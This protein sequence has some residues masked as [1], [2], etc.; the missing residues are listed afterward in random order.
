MAIGTTVL[1]LASITFTRI[2]FGFFFLSIFQHKRPQR[3]FIWS[4]V[5]ITCVCAIV[6]IPFDSIICPRVITYKTC[7]RPWTLTTGY[8]NADNALFVLV[9]L[10]IIIGDFGFVIMAIFALYHVQL[11]IIQKIPVGVL[12]ALGTVDGVFCTI[13]MAIRIQLWIDPSNTSNAVTGN[14]STLRWM[15]LEVAVALITANLVLTRPLFSLMAKK[16][17]LVTTNTNKSVSRTRMDTTF[18]SPEGKYVIRKDT[19]VSVL[20]GDSS[21]KPG[22]SYAIDEERALESEKRSDHL[23][24]DQPRRSP[25]RSL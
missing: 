24:V 7:A 13:R 3:I 4:A 22:F 8:I 19:A 23:V 15:F 18:T 6:Y 5:A 14:L 11:P 16:I 21:S 20:E 1:C 12:L 17:G 2:S 10:T 25:S 9:S